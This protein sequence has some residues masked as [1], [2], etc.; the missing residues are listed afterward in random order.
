MLTK[1][2]SPAWECRLLLRGSPLQPGETRRVDIVF[3]SPEQAVPA[4]RAPGRFYLWEGRII[5]EGTPV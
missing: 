4:I 5:G 2:V 3:L 1:E